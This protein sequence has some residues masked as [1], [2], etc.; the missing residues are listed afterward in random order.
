MNPILNSPAK[1]Y[2]AVGWFVL[3]LWVGVGKFGPVG[4]KTILG[5][6]VFAA[7]CWATGW[8]EDDYVQ[9]SW[10]GHHLALPAMSTAAGVFWFYPVTATWAWWC[11]LVVSAILAGLVL[12]Y[13]LAE[14][15]PEL[16]SGQMRDR[17]D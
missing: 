14:N 17:W 4:W 16:P 1:I 7:L 6:A 10:G 8:L 2:S 9:K 13:R 15:L 12:L 11:A 3:T 5:L